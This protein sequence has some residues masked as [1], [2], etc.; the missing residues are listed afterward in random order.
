MIPKLDHGHKH[1]PSLRTPRNYVL[2][3]WAWRAGIGV[4]S[5]SFLLG[6]WLHLE[7]IRWRFRCIIGTYPEMQIGAVNITNLAALLL[8]LRLG[9]RFTTYQQVT[10]RLDPSVSD[11]W[12]LHET[13]RKIST[14]GGVACCTEKEVWGVG[15]AVC[16][17]HKPPRRHF[18]REFWK[19]YLRPTG[20]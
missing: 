9:Y 11:A 13:F 15:S 19:L 6:P 17:Q 5:N 8:S 18:S 7:Y 2:E 12:V 4:C 16:I 20:T 1:R 14:V 10:A 3:N